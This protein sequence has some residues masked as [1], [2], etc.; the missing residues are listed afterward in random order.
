MNTNARNLSF[1]YIFLFWLPLAAT[2][3]MMAFEGP[4][5]SAIIARM[6]EPKFNLAAYGVAFSFAIIIESPVIQMMSA[7]TALVSNKQ[8][9]L[10]LRNFTYILNGL[11]TVFMLFFLLPPIFYYITIDLINLPKVVAELTHTAV[12]ILLPWPGSIGYRR[13]YQGIL[14]KNNQTRRVAYGTIIRLFCMSSTAIILYIFFDV[15]GVVVGAS[16]LTAGVVSEAIASRFMTIKLVRRIK[17]GDNEQSDTDT[18]TYKEILT[19]Y[20]PL[21]LTSLIGLGVHPLVTF[22]IG[23]SRMSLESLAILPVMNSLVFIFRSLGLSF[24]EAVIALLGKHNEEYIKLRNFSFVM[25]VMVVIVLGVTAFT[26]LSGIWY[27][28]VSGL[29]KE[30]T[31]FAQLPTMIMTIMPGLTFLIS[32]QRGV[33]VNSRKTNPITWATVIEVAGIIIVIF[34]M[35]HLFDSVG[36]VAAAASFIIGRLCANA[37]L[38]PPFFKAIK[39]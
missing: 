22:F 16:A 4:F 26:P 33:L 29:S 5:L 11:M 9:F 35:T 2:W 39:S 34:I 15:H 3:L 17:A 32:F 37:Y 10:K 6:A 30:L 12:L 1:S 14:I 20:N 28:D 13:F 36:A 7:A 25:G 23:Q 38:F 8:T 27:G 21:M 18:L 19:F 24:Q 31:Q